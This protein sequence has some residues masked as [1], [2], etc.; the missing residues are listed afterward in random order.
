MFLLNLT[1]ATQTLLLVEGLPDFNFNSVH[2]R[3]VTSDWNC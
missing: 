3:L 1:V 2:Y